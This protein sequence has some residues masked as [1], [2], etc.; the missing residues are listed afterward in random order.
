MPASGSGISDDE[1]VAA[2]ARIVDTP[3]R[4]GAPTGRRHGAQGQGARRRGVRADAGGAGALHLPAPGRRQAADRGAD[5]PQGHRHRLRD[6]AAAL[7][8]AAAALPDVRGRRLPRAPGRRPLAAQGPGRPRGADGRGRRRGQRQGRHHRRRRVRAE[9]RQHRARHGRRR[10]AARHRPRQAAD[11][12]LALQQPG[13]RAGVVQAGPGAAGDGGRHGD[14]RGADPGRGGPQAGLQRAGL[15]DEA[16]LGAGRHRGRPGRLLRGH[17]RHDPLRPDVP[18]PRLD[19]LLRGQHARRGAQH[20]DLRADQR[21]HAVRRGAGHQGLGA[22]LPRRP[23]P[24]AGAQHPRRPAHQQAGRR[25][26]SAST[27]SART[28]CWRRRRDCTGPADSTGGARAGRPHLPR[29]PR[30]R[31]RPRGQHAHVVPPRP[32]PLPRAPRPP[33]RGQPRRGHRGD[34][35]GRSWSRC[36]RAT[37]TTRR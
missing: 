35:V 1:Y 15:A 31:A 22:G 17:P 27:R 19:L 30:G 6:R 33:G 10:H 12:V 36:A 8:R 34:G 21:D 23:Q 16:R 20:L 28:R 18:G 32:A 14:R 24:A 37:P 13:A 26:A 5:E 29:P 2:G 25:G 9:R 3:R 7:G 11:V 4:R